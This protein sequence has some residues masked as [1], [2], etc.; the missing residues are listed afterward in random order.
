MSKFKVLLTDYAW[1]ELDIERRTLSQI[2]AELIV[3]DKQDPAS[4]AERAQSA[5]A[6]MTNWAQVPAQVIEA[7][8]D[9]RIVARLGIGLDNIDVACATRRG[10]VVTNVPDYCLVEV[11][12]H[13]LALL[14]ALSRK[15]AFYHHET[16]QNRYQLQAGP[17]LR[18]IAGQTLGIVGLGHIGRVLAAKASALNLKLLA[19]SRSRRDPLPG[20]SF[21]SLDELLGASDYVS[22]HTP[23]TAETRHM[24]GAGAV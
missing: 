18:R 5:H 22:L 4:L 23:L 11:A 16:K 3:A 14:L 15:V 6:I 24:I 19:T 10:I 1:R 13:A 12:E 17:P 7:A 20:V 8:A 9:C 2:G 21:V